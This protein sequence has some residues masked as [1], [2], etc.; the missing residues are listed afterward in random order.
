MLAMMRTSQRVLGGMAPL[1]FELV[2]IKLKTEC[3]EINYP[4]HF[5]L[6]PRW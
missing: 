3:V 6:G 5:V 4:P 1:E 2:L